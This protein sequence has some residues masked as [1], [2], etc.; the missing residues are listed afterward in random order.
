MAKDTIKKVNKDK[1]V[2]LIDAGN[3]FPEITI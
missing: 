2:N 1:G 3:Q